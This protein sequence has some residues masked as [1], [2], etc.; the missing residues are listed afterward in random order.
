MIGARKRGPRSPPRQHR[1]EETG[2]IENRDRP[3][4]INASRP[5]AGHEIFNKI[6]G[7]VLQ[8]VTEMRPKCK[9][10]I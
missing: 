1:E 7:S 5:L 9:M 3:I 2:L 10:K 8:S 4:Y 6:Q